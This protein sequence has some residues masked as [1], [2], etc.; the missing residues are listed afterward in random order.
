VLLY[1]TPERFRTMGMGVD[2]DE[3]DDVSLRTTLAAAS[4]RVN[5][6]CAAPGRPVPHDFRGGTITNERHR[7][8][9]A[10]S[11]FGEVQR[12]FYLWH[13]PI[14]S[15]SSVK[16]D[17]TNQQYID[18]P[19]DDVYVT[20]S[21]IE[22]VSLAMTGNGLFGAAIVPVIGLE[23]VTG[24]FSYTYGRTIPIFWDELEATDARTYRAQN[25]WWTSD[26]VTVEVDG[27]EVTT[28][29]TI[30]R[31]EGTIVFDAQQ[32]PDSRI[33]ASYT[34]KL[35]FDIAYATALLAAD[36]FAD[37]ET[38]ARGMA[39]LRSLKVGEITMEKDSARRGERMGVQQSASPEIMSLLD[40]YRFM[41]AGAGS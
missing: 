19:D 11:P 9:L 5:V 17:V 41:S 3:V 33:T 14:I 29:F 21:W 23:N 16:F 13:R 26:D 4:A 7:V 12:K 34:T 30:N 40:G 28:G 15:V 27:V 2:L 25:Q 8:R 24:R 6:L 32:D 22:I 18:F 38:R 20:E 1:V 10:D 31:D 36:A 35:P 37:R 39:G